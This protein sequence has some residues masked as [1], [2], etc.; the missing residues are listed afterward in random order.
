M[1]ILGET[2]RSDVLLEELGSY[3]RRLN[4]VLDFC[5]ARE[6]TQ[7]R[8]QCLLHMLCGVWGELDVQ[9]SNFDVFQSVGILCAIIVDWELAGD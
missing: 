8:G 3:Y 6:A 4:I 1:T 7:R 2:Y 9:L 5:L